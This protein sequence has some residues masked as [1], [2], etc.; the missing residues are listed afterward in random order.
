MQEGTNIL[1][2][3]LKKSYSRDIIR[4]CGILPSIF[5]K[6]II[7]EIAKRQHLGS[8]EFL[9]YSKYSQFP[10]KL[11]PPAVSAKIVGSPLFVPLPFWKCCLPLFFL[12]PPLNLQKVL[13]THV[14]W[15][16]LNFLNFV[17]LLAYQQGHTIDLFQKS[18]TI[19]LTLKIS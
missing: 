1:K 16:F 3:T 14:F 13:F 12:N 8:V 10:P 7:L 4:W 5:L 15:S 18:D 19:V 17:A 6:N 9:V 2:F 11:L